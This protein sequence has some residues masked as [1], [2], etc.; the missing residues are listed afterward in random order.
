MHVTK[1]VVINIYIIKNNGLVWSWL[2]A[3]TLSNIYARRGSNHMRKSFMKHTCYGRTHGAPYCG[4]GYFPLRCGENVV[5]RIGTQQQHMCLSYFE[6]TTVFLLQSQLRLT[7]ARFVHL[8]FHSHMMNLVTQIWCRKGRRSRQ[9]KKNN[10]NNNNNKKNHLNYADFRK[11]RQ[12]ILR[13]LCALGPCSTSQKGL[14][15]TKN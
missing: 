3:D 6:S 8:D 9:K 4:H 11:L 13:V 12:R 2:S 10:N 1:S 5:M 15:N 14:D 7:Y